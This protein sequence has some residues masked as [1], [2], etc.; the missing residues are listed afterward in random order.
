M[1]VDELVSLATTYPQIRDFHWAQLPG[2]SVKS[3]S[4]R[5]QYIADKVIPT[6]TQKLNAGVGPA[7]GVGG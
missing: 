2:E 4:E 1:A 7:V 6:V 5:I 3:G